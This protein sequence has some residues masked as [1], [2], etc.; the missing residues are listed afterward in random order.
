MEQKFYI[1]E[2]CG[3]IITFLE[4][5]GVPVVCCGEKMK[6]LKPGTVEASHEKHIP[7]ISVEEGRVNVQIGSLLHPM[8]KE[9]YIEWIALETSTGIQI[10]YLKPEMEPKAEF[11]LADGEE[12]YAAYAY[13]NLHGLWKAELKS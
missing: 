3:N 1:C 7:A 2:R 11:L 4:N 6:E 8:E 10:R 12:G 13:C 5:K 9:H